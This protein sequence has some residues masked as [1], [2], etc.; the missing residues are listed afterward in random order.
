MING[1]STSFVLIKISKNASFREM[2]KCI[3]ERLDW[4]NQKTIRLFSTQGV[5]IF[6]DDLDFL[7]SGATLYVSKGLFYLF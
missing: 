5:E 1:D 2:S 4:K 6:Q 3:E 7:K